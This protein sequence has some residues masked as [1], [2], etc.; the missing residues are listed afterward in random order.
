MDYAHVQKLS[1]EE[2]RRL[3][4]V[5]PPTFTKMVEILE[6]ANIKRKGEPKYRGGRPPSLSIANMLLLALDYLRE[7]RTMF[8]VA[9]SF[10]VNESTGWRALHFVENTLIKDG[11]FSLP[12]KKELLRSD[13]EYELVVV[14]ATETAIERP[15]KGKS[16]STPAKRKSTR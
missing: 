13:V 6:V 11:T 9:Q 4:G 1:S 12:G 7:Y 2:F 3:T 14:D 8:H 5:K 16:V 10:G 15:K